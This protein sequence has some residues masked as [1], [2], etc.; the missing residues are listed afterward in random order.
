MLKFL[1]AHPLTR[2]IDI[3]RPEMTIL[4]VSVIRSKPFLRQ[5]YEEWYRML[6][7]ELSESCAGSVLEL[8]SG[9]GFLKDI[10]PEAL[11]SECFGVPTVD[12]ILDA[13]HMPVRSSSLRAIFMTNV[14]HHIPDASRFLSEAAHCVRPGGVLAMIEPW[15]TPWS[16]LVYGHLHHEPFDAHAENWELQE[17]GGP[18]TCANNALPWIIFQRDREKFNRRFPEWRIKHIHPFM[19]FRYLLAGGISLRSLMWNWTFPFWRFLEGSLAPWM[20]RLAMF[21]NIVLLRTEATP[22]VGPPF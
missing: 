15:V 1:L 12:A 10:I 6:R 4:R 18:L 22:A 8:G 19:P 11:T 14:L 13:Q 7:R 16:S 5:I 20:D 2:G 17:T 9:A 3:D 21:A